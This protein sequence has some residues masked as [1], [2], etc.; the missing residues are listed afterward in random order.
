MRVWPPIRALLLSSLTG[1]SSVERAHAR[2]QIGRLVVL[3]PSL[4]VVVVCSSCHRALLRSSPNDSSSLILWQRYK[5]GKFIL[6]KS[7][8]LQVTAPALSHCLSSLSPASPYHSIYHVVVDVFIE[9]LVF[10]TLQSA[11]V[12]LAVTLSRLLLS[13]REGD[14]ARRLRCCC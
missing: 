2:C 6:E 11:S 7:K 13:D 12:V 1:S 14:R 10:E 5:E 8:L 3:L 4:F 9:D